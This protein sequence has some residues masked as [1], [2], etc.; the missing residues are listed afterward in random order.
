MTS[1]P[2]LPKIL[3]GLLERM[4]KPTKMPVRVLRQRHGQRPDDYFALAWV[5]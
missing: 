5:L 1:T 2:A 3:E 4:L